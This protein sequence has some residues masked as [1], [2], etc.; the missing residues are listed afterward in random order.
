MVETQTCK[1]IKI[2]KP[3]NRDDPLKELYFQY[4]IRKYFKEKTQHNKV[5][6]QSWVTKELDKILLEKTGYML[7]KC[8]LGQELVG[9]TFIG[10]RFSDSHEGTVSHFNLF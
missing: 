7:A 1:V 8:W 3:D 5:A 9:L 4:D 10:Y 6:E 2:V